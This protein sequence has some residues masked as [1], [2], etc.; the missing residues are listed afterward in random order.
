MLALPSP[1]SLSLEEGHS[2]A[3]PPN[4]QPGVEIGES[5]ARIYDIKWLAGTEPGEQLLVAVPSGDARAFHSET[6][7]I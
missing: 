2:P 6:H 4:Q 3:G 7:C 1:E 5:V